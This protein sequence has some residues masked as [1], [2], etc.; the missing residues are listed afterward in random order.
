M[1]AERRHLTP[2]S[3]IV[4]RQCWTAPTLSVTW[5]ALLVILA[6]V[7]SHWLPREQ[8]ELVIHEIIFVQ[9]NSAPA[10]SSSALSVATPTSTPTPTPPLPLPPSPVQPIPTTPVAVF[11]AKQPVPTP[12]A[13]SVRSSPAPKPQPLAIEQIS[14]VVPAV[15]D[16]ERGGASPASVVRAPAAD[17]G[18]TSV[19]ATAPGY[20]MGSVSTPSPDY[21]Y[22]ARRRRRE[23]V[24]LIGLDVSADGNV[25]RALVLES[26]GDAALDEAAQNT[27]QRWRLRPATEAGRPV[28]GRVEVPVRFR[29]Q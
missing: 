27:L 17:A 26:S 11:K 9:E 18:G 2:P 1:Q 5:H 13:V 12:K 4:S 29:L 10:V 7:V 28:A 23:G 6:V 22:S 3:G 19:P 15:D 25:T 20:H 14:E 24:V 21:P 16:V 8:P